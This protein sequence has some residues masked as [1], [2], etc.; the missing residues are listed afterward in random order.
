MPEISTADKR[1]SMRHVLLLTALTCV[2]TA[3]VIHAQSSL[4]EGELQ[5]RASAASEAQVLLQNGDKAYEE[6]NYEEAAKAYRGAVERL[7][8]NAPALAEQRQAA[9]ERFAQASVE[10]ARQARRLGNIEKATAVIEDVLAP[11]MAP[12]NIAARA[13]Q[14]QILDPIRTNPASSK[15]HT[16]NIE[17][18]RFLLY[19]A[20]GAYDLGKY[21]EA[22]AVFEDVLRVDPT[23]TAARRGMEKVASAKSSYQRAAYDHAR[24]EMLGMVDAAW[25]LQPPPPD[26]LDL[27]Q[28]GVE[29]L[30]TS[31][32][33]SSKLRE[34]IIPAVVMED[35]SIT[36]AVDFIRGQAIE[37]DSNEIDPAKRGVNIVLDLGSN[38]DILNRRFSLNL[39]GLPIRK[40]IDYIT[41]ETGTVAVEQPFALL[42]RPAGSA[43]ADMVARTFRVPP[44]FL[45]SGG[46]SADS[47]SSAGDDPFAADD[48]STG[49]VARRLTARQVLESRGV[50]FPEGA[51]ANF[52][53]ANS[54]LRV[55][56]SI[57][58]LS[59][60]QQ[61]VDAISSDEPA[62]VIVEVKAIRTSQNNLE[63]LGF[64]WILGNFGFAGN[65]GIP[66]TNLLN[67]GGGT[68][69]NGGSL[70]DMPV[71]GMFPA[72]VTAGNRSGEEA[73]P[74]NS[75]DSII[76]NPNRN[77]SIPKRA[78]GALW[79]NG[80]IN[81]SFA[82]VMMR[83][84]SQ[85]KGTD[86]LV[87]PSIVTRSG[88]AASVRVIREFIYPTEYEPPELPN[89]FGDT[90]D[91]VGLPGTPTTVVA[92]SSFPVTP[93][94]PTSFEMREVGVVLDVLPTVSSDK[95]YVD[96][97]LKPEFTDFDGFINYGTP[98]TS[99]STPTISGGGI[100][101]GIGT[102]S[103]P[104]VLTN[105]EILM[106]V[107]SKLGTET[108]LTVANG[109][110]IVIG[111]LLEERT[112]RIEDK[113]P[114]LG[115]L[116]VVGRL[117]QSKVDAP[118]KTALI[119]L[120]H[121]RVVDAAGRPF[122]R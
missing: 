18:V 23:N 29:N 22:T 56:N 105:N 64:D 78:P 11:G 111:G 67:L 32:D 120:V 65:G 43:A 40:I 49:I 91:F 39:R 16:S 59:L 110:T 20:H 6:G 107:F 62:S 14:E 89:S 100:F 1:L 60:V 33:Y 96:V 90:G 97:S 41:Q 83:G 93:A 81:N 27:S 84:L 85:K 66:G 101:G 119:F 47:E 114:V 69:G 76:A 12:D 88:Q 87:Q 52:N 10:V 9:T 57:D 13:E 34:I 75:I 98:I 73:V 80:F 122:D 36:E 53:P 38:E 95:H 108:A 30:T 25:E 42:I 82:N 86:L 116:P 63:E 68:Q 28:V 19:R 106:P 55:V 109:A 102:S 79:V 104:Q 48:E 54:E 51:S 117:F 94:T 26:D 58:N 74:S 50:N 35:I 17:E 45:S 8:E 15:E 4:V 31:V 113:T 7:P 5:R 24:A 2:W 99:G 72:V 44:D 46:S 3:P 77:A 61:I 121:V 21:D 118:V 70:G 115:D 71:G 103:V 92:P 112:R 37:L